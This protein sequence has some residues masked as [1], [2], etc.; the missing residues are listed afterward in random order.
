MTRFLL[1]LQ[2]AV[3]LSKLCA[4][5]GKQ[6]DLFVIKSP[7]C[8]VYTLVSALSMLLKKSYMIKEIGIRPG[9]KIH[10]TLLT[11]EEVAKGEEST[12]SNGITYVRIPAK[13]KPID[14]SESI[15]FTSENTIQFNSQEVLA[16]LKRINIS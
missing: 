16:L 11:G 6:G 3:F 12:N 4:H 9:E 1:T 13:S 15:P 7:A 10:E 5:A 14:Y 2:E 8:T